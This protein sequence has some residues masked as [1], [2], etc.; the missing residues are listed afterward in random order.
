MP[1]RRSAANPLLLSIDGTDRRTYARPLGIHGGNVTSAGWQV[2]LCDPMWHVSSRSGVATLRTAIHLLLTYLLTY[3]DPAP[4][5]ILCGQRQKHILH[6]V[7]AV[8]REQAAA[9]EYELLKL[10][11][12]RVG[13]VSVKNCRTRNSSRPAAA[14]TSDVSLTQSSA[15]TSQHRGGVY[16]DRLHLVS[17]TSRW[18]AGT[19][20]NPRAWYAAAMGLCNDTVSVRP[21]VRLSVLSIDREGLLF[22]KH[23]A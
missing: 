8:H 14:S 15:L 10:C 22:T 4:L 1:A 13:Y 19:V 23:H 6:M 7:D 18:H 11:W 21:S 3:I 9:T 5:R 20:F 2:T 12:S 16:F 17:T